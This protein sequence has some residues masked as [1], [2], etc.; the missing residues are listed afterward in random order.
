MLEAGGNYAFVLLPNDVSK[1]CAKCHGTWLK[2][3]PCTPS[4]PIGRLWLLLTG[5]T[6]GKK[7]DSTAKYVINRKFHLPRF[8]LKRIWEM[9]Q[10]WLHNAFNTLVLIN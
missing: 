3:D 4:A 10:V 9:F 2:G 1:S 5:L 6:A 7:S 8:Y